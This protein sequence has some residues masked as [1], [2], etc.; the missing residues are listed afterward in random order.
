MC[1]P[2]NA[3][4]WL[5]TFPTAQPRYKDQISPGKLSQDTWNNMKQ[6]CAKTVCLLKPLLNEL[7]YTLRV[8]KE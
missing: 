7:Q 5:H 4:P 3:S 6:G 1:R 2:Q 8:K